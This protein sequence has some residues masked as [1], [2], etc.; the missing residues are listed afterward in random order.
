MKLYLSPRRQPTCWLKRVPPRPPSA[1]PA[2]DGAARA[3]SPPLPL[4]RH[5][6]TPLLHRSRREMFTLG[7]NACLG[8]MPA[9]HFSP[10]RIHFALGG[11]AAA[12][13]RG[14]PG[15]LESAGCC[16]LVV[17]V[18][19][20]AARVVTERV[21]RNGASLA[22]ITVSFRGKWGQTRSVRH[23]RLRNAW[24]PC[25]V[26]HECPSPTPRSPAPAPKRPAPAPKRPAAAPKFPSLTPQPPRQ[27]SHR[28][29]SLNPDSQTV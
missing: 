23:N 10:Q 3:P 25:A 18:G 19:T 12:C 26:G 27:N 20:G 14:L 15:Y 9:T 13:Q 4:R 1:A 22:C 11:G 8:S 24:V 2:R 17:E 5:S 6:L 21:T 7:S 16:W 28:P 29:Q